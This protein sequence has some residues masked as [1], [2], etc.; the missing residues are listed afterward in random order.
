M[1]FGMRKK[2]GEIGQLQ[3]LNKNSHH[4]LVLILGGWGVSSSFYYAN[5]TDEEFDA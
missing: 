2:V 4:D 1:L 5:Q 3:A